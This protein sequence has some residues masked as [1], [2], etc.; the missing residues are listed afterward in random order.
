M[1]PLQI[2]SWKGGLADGAEIS[3]AVYLTG[4]L[5]ATDHHRISDHTVVTVEIAQWAI[6]LYDAVADVAIF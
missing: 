3:H 6:L 5:G 2:G 1:R 4:D